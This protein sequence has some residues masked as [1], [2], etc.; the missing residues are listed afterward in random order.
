MRNSSAMSVRGTSPMQSRPSSSE[1]VVI[2]QIAGW[3]RGGAAKPMEG[4]MSGK[5]VVMTPASARFAS[6][7]AALT[8]P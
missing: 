2:G 4:R 8:D 3:K 1:W 5:V 7:A 6:D